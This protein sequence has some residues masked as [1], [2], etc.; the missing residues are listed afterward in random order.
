VNCAVYASTATIE[1]L[2]AVVALSVILVFSLVETVKSL[3]AV[4]TS[5]KEAEPPLP[6]ES[7]SSTESPKLLLAP[8]RNY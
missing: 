2:V 1:S 4:T 3:T 6:F 8:P 5:P 7:F